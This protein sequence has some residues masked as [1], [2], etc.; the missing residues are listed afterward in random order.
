MIISKKPRSNSTGTCRIG[1]IG[2]RAVERMLLR[3][4][5]H[6]PVQQVEN[7]L[8]LC[9]LT[10]KWELARSALRLERASADS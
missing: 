9:V 4:I 2:V 6:A 10:A 8:G 7:N 3:A 5:R 1:R